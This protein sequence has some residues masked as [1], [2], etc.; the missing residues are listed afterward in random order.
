[1]FNT[2]LNHF[3]QQFDYYWVKLL[4]EFISS[5]GSVPFILTVVLGIT[6]AL[7][8]K[9]GIV[10]INIVAWTAML[11]FFAKQEVNYPKPIDVDVTLQ[12]DDYNKLNEDLKDQLPSE[13]LATF[14]DEVLNVTRTDAEENY[15]FPSGHTSIQVALWLGMFFVFRKR[16]ILLLGCFVIALTML[17][18]MYLAHHFLGDILGGLAIGLAVLALLIFLVQKS[19]FLKSPIADFKTLILIWL[20]FLAI[21]FANYL[22]VA[23]LGGLLG[24]NLATLFI[25]LQGNTLLFSP[26][27]FKRILTAVLM[28]VL[29]LIGFYLAG[30]WAL[31]GNIFIQLLANMS[32]Y[33]IIIRG[34]VLLA[35]RLNLLK[36]KL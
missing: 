19:R 27:T 30:K 17:S 25:V 5:L 14:S 24:I 26:N 7:H 32:I 34:G 29:I 16:W 33:F 2:N 28:I 10:L 12:S 13:S 15:G 23:L 35:K 18:R 3:L 22:P 36:Y 20:P 11:T 9:R 21:P 8:F 31:S 1:M 6:F 4:M